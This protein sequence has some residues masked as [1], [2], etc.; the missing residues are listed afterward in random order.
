VIAHCEKHDKSNQTDKHLKNTSG[1]LAMARHQTYSMK[2]ISRQAGLSLATIDRVLHKRDGV[3]LATK[4]RVQQALQELKQQGELSIMRGR[5]FTIDI[6]MEAPQRFSDL[7]RQALEAELPQLQPAMFRCR[8]Q[9][10]E[11]LQPSEI[12]T[13]LQKISRRGS[14]GIILKV[15]NLPGVAEAVNQLVAKRIP[16]ITLVTD[17]PNSKRVAYVGIDNKAAGETAAYLMG[18]WL[19]K[20]PASI[21]VNVSSAGFSGE[22]ERQSAF[23]KALQQHHPH[24]TPIIVSEGFGRNAETQILVQAAIGQHPNICATYSVGGANRA[25]LQAFQNTKRR[26]AVFI[27]HDLDADNRALLQQGKLNAVLHHDLRADMRLS[28]LHVM[29]HNV[30][31]AHGIDHGRSAL[32]VIT[33]HNIPQP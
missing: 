2:E 18:A 9:G 29:Q 16:V 32:Q 20:T 1:N 4:K 31:L 15:P 30:V 3:R 8:F 21:L 5:K 25:V 10:S 11:V 12:I 22:A 13:L 33:P 23:R 28:C 24:L 14:N 27:A 26:C 6:V 7:V 17:I 19:A